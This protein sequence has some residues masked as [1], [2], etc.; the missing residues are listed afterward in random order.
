MA[1]CEGSFSWQGE[2]HYVRRNEF[3]LQKGLCSVQIISLALC[4]CVPAD[5]ARQRAQETH[6]GWAYFQ[7]PPPLQEHFGPGTV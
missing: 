3:Q 2:G 5:A 1:L 6:P 7:V 4:G